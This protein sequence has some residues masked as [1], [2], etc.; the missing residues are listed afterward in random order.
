MNTKVAIAA[1]LSFTVFAGA[2]AAVLSD[3]QKGFIVGAR[4]GECNTYCR[5]EEGASWGSWDPRRDDCICHKRFKRTDVI[6]QK[7][8]SIQPKAKIGGSPSRDDRPD[9]S[10]ED[11]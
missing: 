2:G 4:N 7:L 9:P 11:Y 3:Y 10:S 8:F 1:A 6:E 5:T